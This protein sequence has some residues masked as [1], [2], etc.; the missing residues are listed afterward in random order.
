MSSIS[1]EITVLCRRSSRCLRRRTRAK[2]ANTLRG[3]AIRSC[4]G[5]T[6]SSE[7]QP[8]LFPDLGQELT[9]LLLE[10]HGFGFPLSIRKHSMPERR[11]LSIDVGHSPHDVAP[12]GRRLFLNHFDYSEKPSPNS[13]SYTFQPNEKGPARPLAETEQAPF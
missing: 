2:S 11:E 9:E 8:L 12:I 7:G 10:L 1:M 6:A 5:E 4:G 3:R 13:P